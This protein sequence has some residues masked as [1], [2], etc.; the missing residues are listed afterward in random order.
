MSQQ[1]VIDSRSFARDAG[2]LE[3]SL[4][5]ASLTRVLDVLVDSIGTLSYRVEGRR[6]SR[7]RAQLLLRVE[8]GLSLRCQRCLEGIN[9]PLEV[10]SVLE[11]IDDESDLTQEEL[12][13]DSRDFV[14]AQKELDVAALIEDEIILAL[15]VAPRHENCAV[16][17]AEQGT[18]KLSP[19]SVLAALKGKA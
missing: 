13:D 9:Y 15:P 4:P 19:F 7:D 17:G 8:G 14:P 2:V 12:E 16:P 18:G 11:L 3:G 6:G 1:I 5:I 10:E